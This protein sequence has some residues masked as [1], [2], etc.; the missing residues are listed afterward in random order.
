MMEFWIKV[1]ALAVSVCAFLTYVFRAIR[2]IQANEKAKTTLATIGF[3]VVYGGNMVPLAAAL[4]LSL[5]GASWSLISCL[6]L[7]A[8]IWE[9]VKF[10]LSK[11]SIS[12]VDMVMMMVMYSMTVLTLALASDDHHASFMAKGATDSNVVNAA[13]SPT[14]APSP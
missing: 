12:R 8:T 13:V 5:S 2:F 10:S 4:I 1:F 7:I 14:N 6:I 11:A 9:S 3:I